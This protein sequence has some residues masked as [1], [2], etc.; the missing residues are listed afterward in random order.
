MV[1]EGLEQMGRAEWVFFVLR[2][3]KQ[4]DDSDY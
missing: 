4:E 1:G 3:K 2:K